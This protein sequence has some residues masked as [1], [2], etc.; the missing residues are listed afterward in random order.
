MPQAL[1]QK[2]D[3]L[4]STDFITVSH[5]EPVSKLLSAL[6]KANGSPAVVVNGGHFKGLVSTASL[7]RNVDV[8]KSKVSSILRSSPTI[9]SNHSLDDSIRLMRDAEVRV[10]PIV[11]KEKVTG[12]LPARA[13][14][15]ALIKHP[16]FADV[17]A[18]DL[19]SSNPITIS[20]DDELGKAL[21]IMRSKNIRKL[22]VSGKNGEIVGVLKLEELAADVLLTTDRSARGDSYKK[23][24]G[25]KSVSSSSP[26]T[27]LVKSFMDENPVFVSSNDKA[28]N[29]LK[30]LSTQTNPVVVIQGKGL[31][32]TQDVLNY[33]LSHSAEEALPISITHLPDIDAI[34]RAFI[35]ETLSRTYTKVARV[36][37]S[38]HS[39]KAVFK[40][41]NK[42][43]LRAQTTVKLSLEGAGRP[44]YA[45]STNWKVRLAMK[46]A[47][48]TLE[49]EISHAFNKG[50]SR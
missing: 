8:S 39:L 12:V 19:I 27:V 41:T 18:L 37:K 26:M 49:N 22:C 25:S 13:V 42:S 47:C 5:E 45:E 3:S 2:I 43:G 23:M 1:S 16:V 24:G 40:Q 28:S 6:K 30:A 35:E 34:D 36:L 14:I 11:E 17:K 9:T 21:Q 7:L 20:P 38:D 10:L 50:K 15:G 46:E 4:I 32:T 29:V 48:K 33:Y 31:I 44:I